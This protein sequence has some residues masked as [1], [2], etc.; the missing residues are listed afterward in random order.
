M[1][2]MKIQNHIWL[3]T[4]TVIIM[5][6]LIG[7]SIAQ[8]GEVPN[9]D[10]AYLEKDSGECSISYSILKKH[11]DLNKPD[12]IIQYAMNPIKVCNIQ[13]Q[14][15]RDLIIKTL[16]NLIKLDFY[17]VDNTLIDSLAHE[18]I[19]PDFKL[20][21]FTEI[22]DAYL[23]VNDEKNSETYWSKAKDALPNATDHNARILYYNLYGFKNF[24]KG[25]IFSAFQ[26]YKLAATFDEA[27][28]KY[29]II[30]MNELGNMYTSIGEHD[31]AIEIF[32]KVISSATASDD[33]DLA[34]FGYYGL[35]NSY[36]NDKAYD[37]LIETA[38]KSIEHQTKIENNS[39][40]GYTYCNLG[41]GYMALSKLDSAKH[42][43][44][45]GIEISLANNEYK[46]LKD[47]YNALARYHKKIGENQIAKQYFDKAISINTYFPYPEI[48]RE[49]SDLWKME[50]D[51]KN[52]Y[53]S[54]H[55]YAEATSTQ[56]TANLTDVQLATQIIEDSYE[57]RQEAEAKIIETK[58]EQERLLIIIIAGVITLLFILSF[59]YLLYRN[60]KKLQKLNH[61]ILL[62]NKKLDIALGKQKETIKYLENFA[63]VAAHDLKA[64]IRTA[65]SFA[66][67]L[68]KSTSEKLSDKE[69][70]FLNY[71]DTSVSK[72]SQMIDDLLS[73]SKLDVDLP[74]EE[75]IDLNEIVDKV[76]EQLHNLIK[77]KDS[78]IILE[79]NLPK[80]MGHATLLI[81]LFQNII[82]NSIT[83]NKTGKKTIVKI[84]HRIMD[85]N[86]VAI[87]ITDN[88]GGIP[89]FI[90]PSLFDLFES[91]DKNNGNGIGLATCKK[92]VNHYGGEIW[93]DVEDSIGSTFN[94]TLGEISVI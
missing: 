52:A 55:K 27:D 8:G 10:L 57:Y 41:D 46:E 92:I 15:N 75:K 61:K 5:I 90:L 19:D 31:K 69:R 48:H 42:Y 21:F 45:K 36:Q 93:V 73:L 94:F 9:G 91:T 3:F 1:T 78:E 16:D 18:I 89:K 33:L 28:M 43:Y 56:D 82:K 39:L 86:S 88:S 53:H 12:S 72:L 60:R 17:E 22:S 66:G 20:E 11:V 35:M 67:L 37:Q 49:I 51:Y 24:S 2:N 54:L 25:N 65:S 26:I 64:P 29:Q 59:L 77:E 50:G 63:S 70:S 34:R 30:T 85:D 23:M 84:N 83:H 14:D 40:L 76:K 71:I 62:R 80:I 13:N 6:F 79:S 58:R 4:T 38:Y 32:K 44:L 68:A 7:N 87:Q 47:N 81:Q 74:P